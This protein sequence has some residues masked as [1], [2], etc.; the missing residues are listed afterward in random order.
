MKPNKFHYAFEAFGVG[1]NAQAFQSLSEKVHESL[2]KRY[3]GNLTDL[4]AILYGQSGL[5]P[6]IPVDGYSGEL[7][8]RYTNF[9][10]KYN[11]EPMYAQTW[12]FV[13]MR[14]ASFPTIRIAQLAMH[15]HNDAH[16]DLHSP[17]WD[18]HFRFGV[19]A[20]KAYK[21]IPEDVAQALAL[22]KLTALA[23]H[24]IAVADDAYLTGHPEWAEIVVEAKRAIRK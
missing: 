9:R 1:V 4:E 22:H 16:E 14:P 23:E 5:L 3:K 19:Y 7:L 10:Y 13:R 8:Y 2:I 6:D 20:A 15:L 21:P 12:R 11:L 18:E 24:V 17:Y